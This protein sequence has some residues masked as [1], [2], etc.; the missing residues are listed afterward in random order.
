[1]PWSKALDVF[2]LINPRKG[3]VFGRVVMSY[4]QI[5]STQDCA[6]SV[7]ETNADSHGVVILAESQLNGRG[8]NGKIW[9]SPRGGLWFSVIT[10]PRIK[11]TTAA[12]LSFAMSLAV[13]ETMADRLRGYLKWPNDIVIQERKAGGILLSTSVSGEHLDYCVIGVGLN[14]NAKPVE[15]SD[16]SATINNEQNSSIS[17]E[18]FLA[19][20]LTTFSKYYDLIQYDRSSI[21][22]NRW[23]ERCPMIGRKIRVNLNGIHIY[24]LARDVETDGSLLFEAERGMMIKISDLN[25]SSVDY[26]NVV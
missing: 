13:C 9:I 26:Q 20:V 19:S 25:S 10:K 16:S 12:L 21:I 5:P 23:K 15:L 6:I 1:M 24:G 11:A 3:C 2:Q 22:L 8:R 17:R 4:T 14:L 18:H 7:A